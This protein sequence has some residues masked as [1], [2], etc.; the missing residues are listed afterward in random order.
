[1]SKRE[2]LLALARLLEAATPADAER[3]DLGVQVNEALD[4][5]GYIT[6]DGDP[7]LSVDAAMTLIPEGWFWQFSSESRAV[8]VF[9]KGEGGYTGLTG[10]LALGLTA[11]C[12][13]AS[14]A[15]C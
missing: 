13:R 11:A 8:H 3:E 10:T 1:M 7:C 14:A 15:V 6:D 2:E 12:L 5:A 9:P 4:I